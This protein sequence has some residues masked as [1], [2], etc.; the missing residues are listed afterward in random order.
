MSESTKITIELVSGVKV[1]VEGE[2]EQAKKQVREILET[3]SLNG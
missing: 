3:V 2:Y 1:T